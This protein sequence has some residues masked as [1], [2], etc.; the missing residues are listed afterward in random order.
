M[1]ISNLNKEELNSLA[2]SIKTRLSELHWDEVVNNVKS[3]CSKI[4]QTNI[5]EVLFTRLL[6]DRFMLFEQSKQ[7]RSIEEK[8]TGKIKKGYSLQE[9]RNAFEFY[10]KIYE[11]DLYK[12]TTPLECNK[13]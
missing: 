11:S 6:S 8:I 2:K 12:K 3:L 10:S 13:G 5:D 4:D 7:M 1:D 9:I